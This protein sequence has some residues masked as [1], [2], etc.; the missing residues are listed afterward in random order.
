MSN[1][2]RVPRSAAAVASARVFA[3]AI[4]PPPSSSI[5][6]SD[7]FTD[8]SDRSSKSAACSASSSFRYSFTASAAVC[9]STTSGPRYSIVQWS[10]EAARSAPA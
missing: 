3:N 2:S 7:G 1:V 8:S 4:A 5:P 10:P 9:S 6:M